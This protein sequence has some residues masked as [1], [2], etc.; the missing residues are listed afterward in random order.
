MM[1]EP[2]R[3]S[4]QKTTEKPLD[5]EAADVIRAVGLIMRCLAR[6]DVFALGI[7]SARQAALNRLMAERRAEY[8]V[9]RAAKLF[10]IGRAR[11]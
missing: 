10:T 1:N 8:V 5:D 4:R 11:Q 2:Y 7:T 6:H 3:A 9:D